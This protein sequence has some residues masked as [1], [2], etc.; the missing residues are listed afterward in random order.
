MTAGLSEFVLREAPNATLRS[1]TQGAANVGEDKD[2][3]KRQRAAIEGYA[4]AAGYEIVDWLY[5]ASVKGAD[6]ITRA[7]WLR[8]DA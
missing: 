2:S 8:G 3:E 7:S 4:K 1:V 5:N 6:P